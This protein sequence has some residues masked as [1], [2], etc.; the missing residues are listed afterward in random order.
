MKIDRRI[1]VQQ[2]YHFCAQDCDDPDYIKARNAVL[3]FANSFHRIGEIEV[4]QL[5]IRRRKKINL[6][7]EE[8]QDE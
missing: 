1:A 5:K 3:K 7:N 6:T 4:K 8:A 2:A